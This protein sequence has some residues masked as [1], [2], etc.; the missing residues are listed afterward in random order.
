MSDSAVM[1]AVCIVCFYAY[2]IVSEICRS[3]KK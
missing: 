3:K 1:F 2:L